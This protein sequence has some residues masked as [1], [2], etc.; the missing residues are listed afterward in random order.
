M[1]GKIYMYNLYTYISQTCI[2]EK[3]VEYGDDF[4][5]SHGKS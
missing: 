4:M 3:T 1:Y 2:S 5:T